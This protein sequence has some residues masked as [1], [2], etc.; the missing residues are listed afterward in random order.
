[1]TEAGLKQDIRLHGRYRILRVLG[2]GGFGIS[3]VAADETLEQDV[4]IKEYYPS[5]ICRRTESG[6]VTVPEADRDDFNRG[7]ERFLKEGRILA[8][9][10][11]VP[12]VVKILEYFEENDT[13]YMVM[14]YIQGV[15]LRTYMERTGKVFSFEEAMDYLTPVIRA[16]EKIHQKGL[17][18]RDIS[19]DN[20]MVQEDGTCKLLDFGSA[21]EYFLEKDR[22]KTMSIIVKNGYA[23]PEQYESKGGSDPSLDVYAI[24]ATLYEMLTGCIPENSVKRVVKDDLYPP[25]AFGAEISPAQEEQLMG[26]GLALDRKDRF[27]SM[28]SMREAFAGE[29]EGKDTRKKKRVSFIVIAACLAIAAAIALIVIPG[30][31]KSSLTGTGSD[32]QAAGN[33]ARGSETYDEFLAFVKKNAEE[34]EL[35][36]DGSLKYTIPEEAVL[37][38]GA[39]CN[40]NAFACKEKDVVD[41]LS[42]KKLRPEK[43]SDLSKGFVYQEPYG[44]V[45]TDF[46]H[47]TEYRLKDGT[48]VTIITD[49]VSGRVMGIAAEFTKGAGT[50]QLSPF[51]GF[52]KYYSTHFTRFGKSTRSDSDQAIAEELQDTLK[53]DPGLS[54]QINFYDY[55]ISTEPFLEDGAYQLY[56][57]PAIPVGMDSKT[58]W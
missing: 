48:V 47:L 23:P 32:S 45:N 20:I 3:Y 44:A 49:I 13:A 12:G 33:Y 29:E 11:E 43:T 16:L 51:I 14:E 35:Q 25:S 26:R 10:F 34:T 15:S 6:G 58:H 46:K 54:G 1:M 57:A 36:E 18:H 41:Y 52:S 9:L 55:G 7:K 37:E 19:P 28:K 5:L 31:G 39:P 38:W 21:R 30:M 50:E 2:Q 27:S 8:S 40:Q 22:E 4:V 24:C 53:N 17:L 56:M 42:E